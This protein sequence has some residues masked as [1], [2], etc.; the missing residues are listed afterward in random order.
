MTTRPALRLM[1][2]FF[3]CGLIAICVLT[4]AI[5]MAPL[6]LFEHDTFFALDGAFRV[7]RGQ[8][9][10]RDFSSA[11]GPV[12]FLMDAAGLAMSGLRPAGIGYANALWGALI[13]I[14]AY[15]IARSR[16]TPAS[17][18]PRPWV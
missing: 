15:G 10:H 13:A 18:A 14:W 17:S 3:F 6:R 12:F 5:G 2:L 7:V 9:P 4:I 11:W 8:V 1:D 16:L